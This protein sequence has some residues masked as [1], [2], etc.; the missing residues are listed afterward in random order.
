MAATRLDPKTA[1]LLY[2]DAAATSN[3]GKWAI[4][5]DERSRA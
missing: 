5:F 2:H 3:D 4:S 1:N